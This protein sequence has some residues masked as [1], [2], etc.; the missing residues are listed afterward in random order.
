M[1]ADEVCLTW[2]QP[3]LPLE[4]EMLRWQNV[5]FS[6]RWQDC[7]GLILASYTVR[8]QCCTST[9]AWSRGMI[10]KLIH[11]ELNYYPQQH[12]NIQYSRFAS[13]I[14]WKV[15]GSIP[16]ASNLLQL[17][18]FYRDID[19]VEGWWGLVYLKLEHVQG[20]T[21]TLSFDVHLCSSRR[22][23]NVA[24]THS[25]TQVELQ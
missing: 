18:L 5:S 11:S 3:S 22:R 8:Y 2:P 7:P 12:T 4:N 21:R 13:T 10:C 15:V 23:R 20:D 16:T 24:T 9:G 14:M 25:H 19:L 6:Q 1:A 17:L